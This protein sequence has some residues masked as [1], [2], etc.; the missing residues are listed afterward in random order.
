ML[1]SEFREDIIEACATQRREVDTATVEDIVR[2]IPK[3]WE[4][5]N[6]ARKAWTILICSGTG[7][8]AE[9]VHVW[10]DQPA[11]RFG[12]TGE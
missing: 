11:P 3:E 7:F 5:S 2:T 10:M 9:K 6:K 1:F 12:A 4:V 8:V